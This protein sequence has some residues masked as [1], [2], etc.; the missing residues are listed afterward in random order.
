[1]LYSCGN[2]TIRE[3]AGGSA[4]PFAEPGSAVQDI[5]VP[6]KEPLAADFPVRLANV[7]PIRTVRPIAKRLCPFTKGRRIRPA[8]QGATGR[9]P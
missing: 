4:R 2:D 9:W 5:V 3:I 7:A 1:M 6:H 8:L